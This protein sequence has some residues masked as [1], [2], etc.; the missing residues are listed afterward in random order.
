VADA[1]EAVK[2]IILM[3]ESERRNVF[4]DHGRMA[5]A[6]LAGWE[7]VVWEDIPPSL[8]DA[9]VLKVG[10]SYYLGTERFNRLASALTEAAQVFVAVNDYT[11]PPP[12]QVRDALREVAARVTVLTTLDLDVFDDRTKGRR[13]WDWW[14]MAEHV[15][16]NKASWKKAPVKPS[17]TDGLIYWGALRPARVPSF[18]KYL[19]GAPYPVTLS[20]ALRSKGAWAELAP[21]ARWAGRLSIDEAAGYPATIY[22]EDENQHDEYHSVAARFYEAVGRG[23][24]MLVDIACHKTF[25]R[26][27]IDVSDWT[28][29]NATEVG[30]YLRSATRHR[31]RQQAKLVQDYFAIGAKQLKSVIRRYVK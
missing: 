29:H 13:M 20:G 12:T 31:A 21:E 6:A 9:V 7:L 10:N 28:V 19:T 14:T 5:Q 23:Q 24:L 16:W 3:H 18:K 15:D 1:E 4:L 25:T 26:A 27:G 17:S 22:L 2:R 11:S 8:K 30:A